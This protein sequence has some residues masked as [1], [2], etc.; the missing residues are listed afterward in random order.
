MSS[1]ALLVAIRSA[2]LASLL[3]LIMFVNIEDLSRTTATSPVTASTT[4]RYELIVSS[5]L[6]DRPQV[7]WYHERNDTGEN[8]TGGKYAID[9]FEPWDTN[10]DASMARVYFVGETIASKE[11][12]VA[13]ALRSGG[14]CTGI[15]IETRYLT[16]APSPE[17]P[18][19]PGGVWTPVAQINYVHIESDGDL[20]LDRSWLLPD[21]KSDDRSF[22][23]LLGTILTSEAPNCARTHLPFSQRLWT[24][25]HLHQELKL[26]LGDSLSDMDAAPKQMNRAIP[27]VTKPGKSQTLDASMWLMNPRVCTVT[28]VPTASDVAV[29]CPKYGLTV[30]TNPLEVGASAVSVAPDEDVR[31]E[32]PASGPYLLDTNVELSAVNPN[33]FVFAHWAITG[34]TGPQSTVLE[35]PAT[36]TMDRDKTVTAVFREA[37]CA[38]E[39][40]PGPSPPY[41]VT[42]CFTQTVLA[43]LAVNAAE[44]RSD[45]TFNVHLSESATGSAGARTEAALTPKVTIGNSSPLDVTAVSG[46]P[47]TWS[48]A[49]PAAAAYLTDGKHTLR[50]QALRGEEVVKSESTTITVDLTAPTVS[51]APPTSL[52]VSTA[53]TDIVPTTSDEDIASYALKTGSTLPSGLSLN[54]TSGV[55][56]GTPSATTAAGA[57]TIVVTDRAGNTSDVTLSLPAVTGGT[58]PPP[59]CRNT[60][61][62]TS[63]SN[64]SIIPSHPTGQLY[65]CSESVTVTADPN[66]DYQVD[67]WSGDCSGSGGTC[68]LVMNG[69]RTASVTFKAEPTP[70][71]T[72]DCT[73]T[74]TSDPGGTTLGG[75]T[76]P[77][78]SG[79]LAA[80][81][82]PNACHDFTGWS[83]DHS[84]SNALIAVEMDSD[85]SVH[86]G[87]AHDGSTRTLTVQPS[88]AEAASR[89][90]SM[91]R[92][93]A[94]VTP[95]HPTANACWVAS[96]TLSGVT[97]TGNRTVTADYDPSTARYTLSTSVTG[98]GSVSPSSGSYLC[99]TPVT[100]SAS[101]AL[102]QFSFSHWEGDC[103]GTSSTC[104]LT[105]NGPR[106]ATAV[107]TSGCDGDT[108]IGCR[109]EE[110]EED[111][112]GG[113]PP[114]P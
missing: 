23:T 37:A 113:A 53:L 101:T 66:D 5:G 114:P 47:G 25:N 8:H 52:T 30:A 42:L 36:V 107:F 56:S 59:V 64:G 24:G 33:G 55:I 17:P 43:D 100:L 102:V 84:G 31:G 16:A 71:P 38:P 20:V 89:N 54:A 106:S 21:A 99:G 91:H 70:T 58:G 62:T 13:R 73:L 97:M 28:M 90:T 76:I 105:M 19:A 103:S 6:V 46:E 39:P 92:C 112:E 57:V 108:G 32:V 44:R 69:P 104:S 94:E 45:W 111:G 26:V 41:S 88:P 60:L 72:L 86:A 35:N 14:P 63:G 77:C 50:V 22:K 34:S 67:S 15:T 7:N 4:T 49:V 98:V 85:K 87:F 40:G 48:V 29:A 2:G 51:Y 78:G 10:A 79:H 74:V 81:A 61:T 18:F 3:V 80:G 11:R 93:G 83:G 95:T 65:D 27:T 82:F 68:T 1:R 110:E 75:G 96:G 9:I 109:Q 12:L